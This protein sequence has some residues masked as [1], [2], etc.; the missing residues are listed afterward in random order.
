MTRIDNE[1]PRELTR[2]PHPQQRLEQALKNCQHDLEGLHSALLGFKEALLEFEEGALND[3]E[4]ASQSAFQHQQN[5]QKNL[6]L[7]SVAEV[8][9][10]LGSDKS[11]VYQ[12]LRSGEIPSLTLPSPTSG[13][14]TKVRQRDLEEYIR[15]QR[16]RHRTLVGE[17]GSTHWW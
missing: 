12:K 17:N 3:E 4:S 1:W 2:P 10:R 9:L 13:L 6:R 8:C 11:S 15:G 16:R 5:D 7:L 14:T